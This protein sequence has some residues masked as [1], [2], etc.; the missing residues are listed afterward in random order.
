MDVETLGAALALAPKKTLPAAT[1]GDAGATLV[2]D[3][4]GKWAK[5]A[6]VDQ[7]ISVSGTTLVVTT[8]E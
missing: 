5:G 1:S 7:A 2:V 6:V 3:S 8:A 4:N